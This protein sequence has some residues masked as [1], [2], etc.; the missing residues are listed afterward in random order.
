MPL[1][2]WGCTYGFLPSRFASINVQ[3]RV[4]LGGSV[5]SFSHLSVR[6]RQFLLRHYRRHKSL[7]IIWPFFLLKSTFYFLLWN[8]SYV[9]NYAN[10]ARLI[11]ELFHCSNTKSGLYDWSTISALSSRSN[12]QPLQLSWLSAK[13]IYWTDSTYSNDFLTKICK[14]GAQFK[15]NSLLL[16][17]LCLVEVIGKTCRP[18]TFE[19]RSVYGSSW[20]PAIRPPQKSFGGGV[21][22]CIL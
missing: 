9:A 21:Y 12:S 13:A 18:N 15:Y 6:K 5:V 2:S 1:L 4:G 14:H 11:V 10:Y 3:W 19:D 20:S 16:A 8:S 17:V 7:G 22:W